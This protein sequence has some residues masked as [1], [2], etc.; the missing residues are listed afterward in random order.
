FI[1][2]GSGNYVQGN[3][4]GTDVTGKKSVPND[5][6]G[7]HVGAVVLANA[8]ADNV[9][10]GFSKRDLNGNLFGLGNLISGNGTDGVFIAEGFS[11]SVV[12]NLVQGNFIGTDVTGTQ[13]LSNRGN[14]VHLETGAIGNIIGGT[15][16]GLGNVI[17]GNG[18]AAAPP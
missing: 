5:S 2:G 16:V 7:T 3:F 17:S 4:I 6:S 9:I 14:G 15:G 18:D 8:A 13:K 11:T 1:S 12:G 10:G